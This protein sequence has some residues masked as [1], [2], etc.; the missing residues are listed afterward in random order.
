MPQQYQ[1][2]NDIIEDHESR[3]QNLK[4]YYPFFKLQESTFASYKEGRFSHLH[5]GYITMASLRFFIDE[6]NFMERDVSFAQYAEFLTDILERDFQCELPYE[7]NK[8][9]V[10]F[11]FDKLK[12]E[13]SPFYFNYFDPI[14]GK[15]KSCR[16]KYIES[17][18]VDDKVLYNITVDGI[19]FYLDTKE[20]KDESKINIQQ[21]LLSKMI[22]TRNFRGGIEV[23]RRIN[24][25]VNQLKHKKKEVMNL[26]SHDI[27]QGVKANEEFMETAARWFEE[28]QNLF[29]K[30]KTLID[31]ALKRAQEDMSHDMD[32]EKLLKYMEDIHILEIEL[33]KSIGKHGDLIR[34]SIALQRDTDAMIHK[35]KLKRLRS[36]FDF[37]D[38]LQKLKE[39]DDAA[40]L[41]YLIM[42]LL[43]VKVNKTFPMTS[44]DNLLTYRPE[45]M[46]G[47]EKIDE[48]MVPETYTYKD[49]L[50]EER[51]E[52]NFEYMILELFDQLKKRGHITLEELNLCFEQRFGKNIFKNGDY[53]SFLVHMCQKKEYH[54]K[55]MMEETDTFF[56]GIVAKAFRDDSFLDYEDMGFSIHIMDVKE[57]TI[58][59]GFKV[60]NI[61]FE[62][63][64]YYG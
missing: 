16:V 53:Y 34:E 48:H 41:A 10:I 40:S 3:M 20:M 47:G 30:N 59:N 43:D 58:L 15:H 45:H 18:I 29:Q 42:P 38:S 22:E 2:R 44:I 49:E 33:K 17:K 60:S 7:E 6:N 9:L 52:G 24:N 1:Y 56:E 13:G 19:E 23:V 21:L 4:R 55:E 32:K 54:L 25:Q 46:T 39:K 35:A 31:R 51:I 57:L 36:T 63:I 37:K 61:E 62:R 8:E 14:E 12:N 28:E 5:M 27:F 50:E 11:I 26:M 64:G